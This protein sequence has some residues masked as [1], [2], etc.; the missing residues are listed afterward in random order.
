MLQTASLTLHSLQAL[1]SIGTVYCGKSYLSTVVLLSHCVFRPA[2]D[3]ST[4]SDTWYV[5]C[6]YEFLKHSDQLLTKNCRH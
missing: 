6:A 2:D 1:Y 4:S 5:V 3:V